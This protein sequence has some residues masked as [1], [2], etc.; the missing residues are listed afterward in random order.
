MTSPDIIRIFD[1]TL[2]DGEQSPGCSMSPQQKMVMARALDALGVDIIE[3]GFP[4]S[5]ESDR[6]AMRLIAREVRR[7]TLAVLSRL[8][9]CIGFCSSA[10]SY[11]DVLVRLQ[12]NRTCW[13]LSSTA[14]KG[15][16]RNVKSVAL[17]FLSFILG[18]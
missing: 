18:L 17:H 5:S 16:R 15:F 7:P 3:T 1:T 4:A 10:G 13:M 12:F 9:C 6:D 8:F 14:H 11:N 2:R